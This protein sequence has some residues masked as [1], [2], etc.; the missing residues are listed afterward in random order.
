MSC[1][2]GTSTAPLLWGPWDQ[3][4]PQH[5]VLSPRL[6]TE[7][8]LGPAFARD[9]G[10]LSAGVKWAVISP[11]RNL[12][13][14]LYV[15]FAAPT[16]LQG[17]RRASLEHPLGQPL[18]QGHEARAESSRNTIFCQLLHLVPFQQ[19]KQQEHNARSRC[20][21]GLRSFPWLVSVAVR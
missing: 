14:S 7:G 15:L 5:P 18:G 4:A 3:A 9:G 8:P 6:G 11:P 17:K 19:K 16:Y 1:L 10:Q 20:G 13:S 2:G 12:S 21:R